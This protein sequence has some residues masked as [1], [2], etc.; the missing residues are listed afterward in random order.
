M[1]LR[2]AFSVF[3]SVGLVICCQ[4]APIDGG[5]AGAWMDGLRGLPLV[6]RFL[7]DLQGRLSFA[8]IIL[9]EPAR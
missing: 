1:R 6:E 4:S 5:A 8:L 2:R 9:G 7:V 3:V